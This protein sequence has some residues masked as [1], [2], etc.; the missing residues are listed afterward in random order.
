MLRAY[1]D[2]N[3]F[4]EP[5][6]DGPVRVVFLHGWARRGQDFVAC[7][8]EL[9]DLGTA[10]VALDLPGFG[11]SPPPTVAGGARHYAQL[12]APVLAH[13]GAEPV[14]L[15]GHSYGGTVATVIAANEPNLVSGL[16]LT[17]APL[18]RPTPSS[19]T[20]SPWRFRLTRSLH[21]HGLI[22]DLKME[23]ARQHYGSSD[24]RNASGIMRDVLVAA[25]NESYE[26]ELA[27]VRAPVVMVWGELDREVP[28]DIASR[29]L[30]LLPGPH[31]FR[32]VQGVGHL[33]P[34]EAPH[35]L[36]SSTLELL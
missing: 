32:S 15:V 11:S 35:E 1:G 30:A 33:L 36:L 6:G 14:V 21:A 10:S 18:L 13:I 22:S 25:V 24:Y 5:Y 7:A 31:R 12:V 2:G 17:G 19:R 9:A 29:A 4:G 23:A 26:D 27:R 20:R 16:V 3:L 8:R 34:T 28:E